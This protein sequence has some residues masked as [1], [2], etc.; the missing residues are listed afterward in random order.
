MIPNKE[1]EG[2][3]YFPVKSLSALLRAI[4]S[5]HHVDFYGLACLH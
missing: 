4:T 1:K 5:K 2:W 3:R